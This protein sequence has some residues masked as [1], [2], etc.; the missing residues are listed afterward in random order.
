MGSRCSNHRC[1]PDGKKCYGCSDCDRTVLDQ[2]IP[3]VRIWEGHIF[4]S[5][6]KMPRWEDGDF[7]NKIHLNLGFT[8]FHSRIRSEEKLPYNMILLEDIARTIKMDL[9]LVS[10]NAPRYVPEY[11]KW[12]RQSDTDHIAGGVP[13]FSRKTRSRTFSV[14]LE[15]G[16]W[17]FLNQFESTAFKSV[18]KKRMAPI[19]LGYDERGSVAFTI[20][21]G[22]FYEQW[23]PELGDRDKIPFIEWGDKLI[24]TPAEAEEAA[25]NYVDYIS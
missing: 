14:G 22:L 18:Y 1:F 6:R 23:R 24:E 8:K 17:V 9:V 16:H 19:F 15:E 5:F 13:M 2:L 21:D 4:L 20:G 12:G 10:R 3:N 7:F 11:H 25:S